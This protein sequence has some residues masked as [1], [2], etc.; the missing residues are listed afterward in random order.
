MLV[1]ADEHGTDIDFGRRMD[2]K[3]R[4][5]RKHLKVLRDSGMITVKTE[6]HQVAGDWMNY[7]TA[8]VTEKGFEAIR[9]SRETKKEGGSI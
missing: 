4:M 5:I 1:A 8:V 7:R 6:R 3:P 9:R 2:L